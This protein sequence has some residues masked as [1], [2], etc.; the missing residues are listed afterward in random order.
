MG[1]T[2]WLA[3]F[4]LLLLAADVAAAVKKQRTLAIGLTAITAVGITALW[5]LWVSCLM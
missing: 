3:V 4:Y 1:F 5:L 2:V